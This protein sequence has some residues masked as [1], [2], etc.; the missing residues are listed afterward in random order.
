M[1]LN[2]LNKCFK[3][4]YTSSLTCER[5]IVN[6]RYLTSQSTRNETD[7]TAP[8]NDNTFDEDS[9]KNKILESSLKFVPQFGFTTDALNQGTI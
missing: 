2:K 6:K 4:A 8:S 3:L 9:I 7:Y 1:F 5:Y